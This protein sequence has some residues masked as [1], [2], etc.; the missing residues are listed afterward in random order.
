MTALVHQQ[1]N[2]LIPPIASE[3]YEISAPH[4][5]LSP[6]IIVHQQTMLS[7]FDS[8]Q[9][10]NTISNNDSLGSGVKM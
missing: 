1:Y 10:G 9:N 8:L 2:D 4:I 3:I 5:L 6:D 7:K